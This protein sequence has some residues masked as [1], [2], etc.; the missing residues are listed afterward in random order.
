[1]WA[2]IVT[3]RHTDPA[4]YLYNKEASAVSLAREWGL[5]W[6]TD[7]KDSDPEGW[8]EVNAPEDDARYCWTYSSEG[9]Y[10]IVVELDDP[11]D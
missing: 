2:I 6:G 3:D 7:W 4:V 11:E 9:D 5:D 8:A 1:M 10:I